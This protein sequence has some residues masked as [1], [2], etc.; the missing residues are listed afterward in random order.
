MINGAQSMAPVISRMETLGR[1]LEAPPPKNP[2]SAKAKRGTAP[3]ANVKAKPRIAISPRPNNEALANNIAPDSGDET[4][5]TNQTLTA[6]PKTPDKWTVLIG[7]FGVQEN[8]FGLKSRMEAAGYPVAIS[9]VVKKNKLWYRLQ[10][11][12]FD[13]KV[14][15]EAYGRELRQRK[16][17]DRPYVKP[18]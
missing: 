10:S 6:P 7:A 16:L 17:V 12:V 8:A 14:S 5:A 1:A 18:L 9:E 2:D 13:D 15:A 3:T 4:T 11:G